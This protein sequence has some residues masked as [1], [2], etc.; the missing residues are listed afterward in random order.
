MHD[1]R[2][3]LPKYKPDHKRYDDMVMLHELLQVRAY[4]VK[5]LISK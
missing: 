5:L 1:F 3:R 4:Q 2:E